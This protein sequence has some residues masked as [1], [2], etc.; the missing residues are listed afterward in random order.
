MAD[1]KYFAIFDDTAERLKVVYMLSEHIRGE[2]VVKIH[3][4][5]GNT[6][7]NKHVSVNWAAVYEPMLNRL[8]LDE[9]RHLY[10]WRS[11][12]C[13]YESSLKKWIPI[14]D[15]EEKDA[16]PGLY[17]YINS[18]IFYNSWA[19]VCNKLREKMMIK[20][21]EYV[22]PPVVHRRI[23]IQ[24]PIRRPAPIAPAAPIGR[25]RPVQQTIEKKQ[26]LVK[27]PNYLA[28]I[29]KRDAIANEIKCGISLNIIVKD[30]ITQ[31]TP[32]FHIFES[33]SLQRWIRTKG[34]C[35]ICLTCIN[36]ELC[37]VL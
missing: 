31:I 25:T 23:L 29:I 13:I 3:A 5:S 36:E 32:C 12:L 34:N 18:Y 7:N 37:T 20:I 19:K 22:L 21:K 8:I 27:P 6:S 15:V 9:S 26:G 30:T 16:I 14:L 4:Y 35:P 11:P 10:M 28:E 1:K 24:D 17:T 2:E 33:T